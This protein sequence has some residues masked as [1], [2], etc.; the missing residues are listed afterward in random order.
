[1]WMR[2]ELHSCQWWKALRAKEVSVCNIIS[3]VFL[4]KIVHIYYIKSPIGDLHTFHGVMYTWPDLN[5][6]NNMRALFAIPHPF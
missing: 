4:Y 1:M 6:I 3:L 5:K 2:P